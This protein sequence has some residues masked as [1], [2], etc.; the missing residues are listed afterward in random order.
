MPGV[1]SDPTE[2]RRFQASLRQFNSDMANSTGRINAALRG[3]GS[4]W[5]DQEYARFSQE[6][7]ATLQGFQRYLQNAEGY[8]R[9]LDGKAGPL[10]EFLG[11]R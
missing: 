7:E 3:L 2:I 4:T 10:E 8:I 9:Y 11:R 6:L 1:H 5:R